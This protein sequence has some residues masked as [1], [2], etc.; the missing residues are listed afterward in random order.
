M[1]TSVCR[2]LIEPH[3]LSWIRTRIKRPVIL[4]PVF[5]GEG[6]PYFVLSR[7]RDAAPHTP[8]T[9]RRFRAF[10]RTMPGSFALKNGAQDDSPFVGCW[11]GG[12][13]VTE[14]KA[15]LKMTARLFGRGKVE[16]CS[17]DGN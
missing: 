2:V 3:R 1:E 9:A 7:R 16:G 5:P 8:N 6:P 14:W 15:A 12:W 13:V 17:A 10:L 4:S 11:E